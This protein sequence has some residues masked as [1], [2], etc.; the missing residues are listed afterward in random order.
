[1]ILLRTIILIALIVLIASPTIAGILVRAACDCEQGKDTRMA[2][3]SYERELAL[4][5]GRR[6]HEYENRFPAYCPDSKKMIL[7]N[8]KAAPE[9]S[10]ECKGEVLPYDDPSLVRKNGQ[11]YD[12]L[13][14]TGKL[15]FED[16]VDYLCPST[17]QFDL[18]FW[19]VG[20]W[21]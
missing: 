17:G 8:L 9:L 3:C 14:G 10:K 4:G 20:M 12:E 21:D 18:H 19:P 1:M 15:I 7:V 6:S 13:K 2:R 16:E 11:P 5:G